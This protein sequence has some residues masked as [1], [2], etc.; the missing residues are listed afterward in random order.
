MQEMS[1]LL[2]SGGVFAHDTAS[3]RRWY[4]YLR[5]L[6]LVALLLTIPAFY[7]GLATADVRMGRVGMGLNGAVALIFGAYLCVMCVL[8]RNPLLFL[9]NNWLDVAI[10]VGATMSV[11]GAYGTWS[12]LEWAMRIAFVMLIALRLLLF[13]RYFFSP[14]G[15]V[16]MVALGAIML[17]LAGAGFFWLEPTVKSYGE[18]LWLAF[19]SG[20]T[21]GYGD[22]VPTT[23]ASRIFAVFMVLLGYGLLSVVTASIAA[24]F[25]GQDE[26][27]L[28][29]EFHHDIRELRNEVLAL[30][31]ELRAKESSPLERIPL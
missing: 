17:G 23:P 16:Y 7:L 4:G 29:R 12:T 25:V 28:R 31:Q 22:I 10:L 30:R 18:G 13:L 14:T 3:A 6:V 11:L 15:T 24:V 21:V 2:G 9:K 1:V 5:W 8:S 20:A 27:K 19:E 26:E